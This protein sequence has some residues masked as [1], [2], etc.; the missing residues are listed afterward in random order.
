M[1]GSFHRESRGHRIACISTHFSGLGFGT[2][3][4]SGTKIKEAQ[5]LY[6]LPKIPKLRRLLENQN[7]K[8]SLQKTHWRSSTS[9]RKVWRP[10]NGRSQSPP[11]DVNL[12]TITG[13]LSWY[14]IL[15]LIGFN[16]I[17]A[18]QT[19][20]HETEKSLSKFLKP[21][22]QANSY[23]HRQ[24]IGVWRNFVKI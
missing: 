24:F 9:S 18:K 2:S 17:R 7:E 8:G 19:S 23:L 16:P 1:V 10:D 15:P 5:C 12:E 3:Y 22:P 6:S 4:E 13:T 20:S 21:S 11:K 14:K